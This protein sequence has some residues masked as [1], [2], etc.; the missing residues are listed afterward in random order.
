MR[1]SGGP[2]MATAIVIPPRCQ[3]W[4]KLDDRYY[5]ADSDYDRSARVL[6]RRISAALARPAANLG[7]LLDAGGKLLASDDFRIQV[8]QR[9]LVGA[10]PQGAMMEL[11]YT[12]S[13]I[14]QGVAGGGADANRARGTSGVSGEWKIDDK[15]RVCTTMT[16]GAGLRAGYAPITVPLQCQFWFRLGDKFYLADSDSDRSAKLLVRTL[17]H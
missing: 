13:G 1:M 7:E 17:K 14:V 4:F 6:E 12:P 8:V 5:V 15:H 3:F 2:R 9:L 16:I 11:M 10:T